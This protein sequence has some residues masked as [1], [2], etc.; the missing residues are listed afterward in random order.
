[1]KR[2]LVVAAL[3]TTGAGLA[4]AQGAGSWA[5]GDT[6]IGVLMAVITLIGIAVL[7]FISLAKLMGSRPYLLL[8]P[9][10]AGV[11]TLK[12]WPGFCAGA[13]EC[14]KP[15]PLM[16]FLAGFVPLSILTWLVA[17]WLWPMP[18]GFEATQPNPQAADEER[19]DR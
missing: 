4:N 16:G 19:V 17:A 6:L 13:G 2:K 7:G 3:V 11:F 12:V 5:T 18:K 9:I 15:L 14:P 10:A 1:M 8:I